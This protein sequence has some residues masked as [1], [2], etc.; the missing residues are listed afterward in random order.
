MQRNLHA[1]SHAVRTRAAPLLRRYV[2]KLWEKRGGGFYGFV[3]T[4]MFLY[5]EVVDIA[6]DIIDLGGARLTLG[7]VI[8]FV[9]S[10]L[11]TLV[12]NTLRAAIWPLTWLSQFGVGV[13]SITLLAGAYLAYRAVRPRV[14]RM[15]QEPEAGKDASPEAAAQHANPGLTTD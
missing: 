3:A 15:L 9:V 8:S 6:G 13:L 10:N 4:L 1:S 5:L 11:V 12:V 2:R 14:L 7:W